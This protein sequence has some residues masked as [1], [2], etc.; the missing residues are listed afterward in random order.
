MKFLHVA[1]VPFADDA[2]VVASR[3]QQLGKG[4]FRDGQPLFARRGVAF[5]VDF[6]AEA[7]L[8]APGHQARAARRAHARA[9]IAAGAAHPVPRDGINVRGRDVL[10]P[11]HAKVSIAQVVGE[12]DEDVGARFRRKR[13]TQHDERRNENDAGDEL[14]HEAVIGPWSGHCS[15]SRT[16]HS[17]WS[18]ELREP[19]HL[20]GMLRG[21]I[22][23]LAGVGCQIEELH[24]LR[25][26]AG[27]QAGMLA[28]AAPARRARGSSRRRARADRSS[29]RRACSWRPARC[30]AVSTCSFQRC[31]AH[32]ARA[33]RALLAEDEVVRALRIAGE[34]RQD[35]A[36]VDHAIGR[37]RATSATFSAVANRSIITAGCALT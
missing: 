37:A 6:V 3:L 20:V 35:V 4:L 8:R 36:S 11:V 1:E 16:R 28:R 31:I 10:A 34:Q 19:L 32:G 22:V 9:D 33:C 7:R 18:P 14:V 17:P 25:R 12:Q 24:R 23:L 29:G 21:H 5:P 2:G 27:L 15:R 13:R 26:V 30:R